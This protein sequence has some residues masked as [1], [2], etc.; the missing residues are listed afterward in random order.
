MNDQSS[1]PLA[2]VPCRAPFVT[3]S[4]QT[5]GRVFAC[6]RK[7]AV[8]LGSVLGQSLREIWDGPRARALRTVMLEQRAEPACGHCL[9][10]VARG[11]GRAADLQKYAHIEVDEPFPVWPRRLEFNLANTCNLECL[12]CCGALSS[13]IRARREGLPPLPRVYTEPFFSELAEFLPHL[14]SAVFLGGEPF[15]QVEC[16]R[17][18][19]MLIDGGHQPQC[20][21]VTNGTVCDA[22]TER[23]LSRLPCRLTVS[24]DGATPETVESIR[25]GASFDVLVA[26]LQRFRELTRRPG[27]ELLMAICAMSSNWHELGRFCLWADSLDASVRINPLSDPEELSLLS[28]DSAQLADVVK[29]LEAEA[30][31]VTPRLGRNRATFVGWLESLRRHLA[32]GAGEALRGG[33]W[34]SRQRIEY[35]QI[36]DAVSR[37]G[38]HPLT[39]LLEAILVD[40]TDFEE[41]DLAMD[42][43]DPAASVAPQQVLELCRRAR[44]EPGVIESWT[45]L[46]VDSLGDAG[47]AEV[48]GVASETRPVG[49]PGWF[50]HRF[51]C[52]ALVRH[53]PQTAEVAMRQLHRT[54]RDG[55]QVLAAIWGAEQLGG[56]DPRGALDLLLTVPQVGNLN[57]NG[58]RRFHVVLGGLA[59]RLGEREPARSAREGIVALGFGNEFQRQLAE[60]LEAWLATDGEASDHR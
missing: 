40:L 37:G 32:S 4:L 36:V 9:G 47:L 23:V 51:A 58:W 54:A 22:E 33:L 50:L 8:L 1:S 3:M 21:I 16:R 10:L 48:L 39:G 56:V 18:F 2:A 45:D 26:N 43:V 31:H 49:S 14:D 46:L 35:L 41:V 20:L 52:Q 27:S 44:R 55:S 30:R 17:I 42:R 13:R 53:A 11:V 25:V 19:S 34:Q 6:C 15:L 38:R 12:H 5:D 24:L 7:P 59:L 28:L 29:E 60:Q 57:P